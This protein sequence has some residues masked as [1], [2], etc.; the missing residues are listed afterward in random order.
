MKHTR[1]KLAVLTTSVVCGCSPLAVYGAA[2]TQAA[3]ELRC[4][5]S[6]VQQIHLASGGYSYAFEGCG[7]QVRIRCMQSS[8]EIVCVST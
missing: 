4:A 7:R 6:D 5:K 3:N 2:K 1:S 8:Y